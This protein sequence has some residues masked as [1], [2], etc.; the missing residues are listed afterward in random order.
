[1]FDLERFQ[2]YFKGLTVE[3]IHQFILSTRDENSENYDLEDD[4]IFPNHRILDWGPNTDTV[5]CFIVKVG[6]QLYLTMCF[7]RE[8]NKVFSCPLTKKYFTE[9]LKALFCELRK[10]I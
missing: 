9:T 10:K 4:D 6:V 3:G 8:E 5:F 1:M 7:D 2:T